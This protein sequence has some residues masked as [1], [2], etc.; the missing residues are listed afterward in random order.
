MA[1]EVMRGDAYG[2]K[3]DVHGFGIVLL[4]VASLCHGE[5]AAFFRR[6]FMQAGGRGAILQGWR[7]RCPP[8]LTKLR[9]ELAQL[10][11]DCYQRDQ[12]ARPDFVEILAR[13]KDDVGPSD[14]GARVETTSSS[15]IFAVE[16]EQQQQQQQ[17]QQ[18]AAQ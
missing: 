1:E 18:V 15:T 11:T 8:E 13:L 10:I 12:T 2:T 14:W 3:V 17:Q 6:Q 7:P 5:Q 4:E 9:P 16:A